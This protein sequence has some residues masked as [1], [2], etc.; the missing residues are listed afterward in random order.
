MKKAKTND[1][2]LKDQFKAWAKSLLKVNPGYVRDPELLVPYLKGPNWDDPDIE[3]AHYKSVISMY[4]KELLEWFMGL[5]QMELSEACEAYEKVL[6]DSGVLAKDYGEKALRRAD[7]KGIIEYTVNGNLMEYW[8]FYDGEGWYFVR[9]DLDREEEV[10]RGANIPFRPSLKIPIPAFLR[11]PSGGL[12][13]NY[14]I[15]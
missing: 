5:R 14:N 8:S 1:D 2:M 12:L 3:Y 10:F 13:Y 7:E 15:G 9:Y 6:W 4:G 11:A